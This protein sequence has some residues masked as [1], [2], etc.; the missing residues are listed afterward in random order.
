MKPYALILNVIRF[1][2]KFA[3]YLVFLSIV[4]IV[5]HRFGEK[6]RGTTTTVNYFVVNLTSIKELNDLIVARYV[7]GRR[8]IVVFDDNGTP[9][10]E[11]TAKV[12]EILLRA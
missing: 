9:D 3:F 2:Y 4:V 12:S 10:E 1:A 7:V 11:G 8:Q 5:L 6:M